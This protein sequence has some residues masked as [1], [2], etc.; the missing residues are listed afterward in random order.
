MT[1]RSYGGPEEGGWWYDYGFPCQG[2]ELFN[3]TSTVP[4]K[5]SFSYEFKNLQTACDT[6]AELLPKVKTLNK[7]RP[8]IDSV[9]S[10]GRYLLKIEEHPPKAW[11][12]KVPHYE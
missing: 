7:G 3:P 1:D 9:L 10:E 12:D 8:K 11:P 5:E 2:K 4:L 6:Y